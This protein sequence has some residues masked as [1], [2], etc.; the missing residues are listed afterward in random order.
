MKVLKKKYFGL[1]QIMKKAIIASKNR[2][3]KLSKLT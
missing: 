2:A 3:D 1:Y